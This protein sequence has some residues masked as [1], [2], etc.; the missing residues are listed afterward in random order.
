MANEDNK[1]VYAR[2]VEVLSTRDFDSLGEVVDPVRYKEICVGL[3]PGWVNLPDAIT[4]FERML[5]GIPDLEARIDDLAAEGDRVYAPDGDGHEHGQLLRRAAHGPTLRGRHVRLRQVGRRQ[6]LRTRPAERPPLPVPADVRRD[7]QEGRSR[8]R[9][10]RR[11]SG[12]TQVGARGLGDPYSDAASS[13]IS[14]ACVSGE[15]S[16]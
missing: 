3:T 10:R 6:D 11:R 13:R 9:P 1:R 7:R 4:A 16:G 12:P 15:T 2:Y 8:V 5:V 14:S